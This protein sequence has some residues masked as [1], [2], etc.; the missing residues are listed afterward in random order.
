M[1]RRELST[2][3]PRRSRSQ[4]AWRTTISYCLDG[5]AD[6]LVGAK[7]QTRL[8]FLA[9]QKFPFCEPLTYNILSQN[10]CRHC[11]DFVVVFCIAGDG[12][13]C[14][15]RISSDEPRR[16]P[17][18]SPA[19]AARVRRA[20]AGGDLEEARAFADPTTL[21]RTRRSFA[22]CGR[23]GRVPVRFRRCFR[24]PTTGRTAAV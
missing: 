11:T 7:K 6:S 10:V 4:P 1:Y 16:Y 12:L 14:G 13:P 19:G 8:S 2:R 17:E 24:R 15:V 22:T 20:N 23:G 18:Q 5:K 21:S 3:N 9:C